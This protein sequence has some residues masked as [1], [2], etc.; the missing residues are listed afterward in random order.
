MVPEILI[1]NSI[2]LNAIMKDFDWIDKFTNLIY[3]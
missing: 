2:L 3:D 1:K